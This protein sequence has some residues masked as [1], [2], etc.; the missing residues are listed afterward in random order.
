MHRSITKR[1]P[2]FALLVFG[3]L[4]GTF[5]SAAHAQE[6]TPPADAIVANQVA[7]GVTAEVLAAAPSMLAPGQTVYVVR[8]VFQPGMAIFP[9]GHPGTTVLGVASGYLGWTLL[10]GTAHVVRGA[11]SANPGA[12]IDMIVPGSDIILGSGDAIYYESDL[13]H[14]ARGAGDAPAVVL[15]SLVLK[16]GAPLLMPAGMNMSTPTP[17]VV[18]ILLLSDRSRMT[19]DRSFVP[20]TRFAT[21]EPA[22]IETRR[23]F[24]LALLESW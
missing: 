6:A 23:R 8:F 2:I 9:H 18:L 22:Q 17:E 4:F 13:I 10:A 5:S 3:I 16:T 11:A 14:T 15:A 7:P 19:I 12:V 24:G 1:L 21:R 20:S